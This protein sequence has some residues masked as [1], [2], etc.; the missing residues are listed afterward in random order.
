MGLPHDRKLI[1]ST[2]ASDDYEEMLWEKRAEIDYKQHGIDYWF[3]AHFSIYDDDSKLYQ[4]ASAKRQQLHAVWTESQFVWFRL[5]EH[6]PIQFLGPMHKAPSV[7]MSTNQM[8]SKRSRAILYKEV[9]IADSLFPAKTAFFVVGG[10]RALPVT[11]RRDYYEINANW[12]MRGLRGRSLAGR[13]DN[14]LTIAQLL[15]KNLKE[16][17]KNVHPATN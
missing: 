17:L 12:L 7:L 14:R 15:T 6:I 5:G 4:F 9:K 10:S 1:L 3:P 11:G 16:V 2:C 13:M 8:Y